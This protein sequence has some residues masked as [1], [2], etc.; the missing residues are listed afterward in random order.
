MGKVFGKWSYEGVTITEMALNDYITLNSKKIFVPHSAGRFNTKRFKKAQ[1]PIVERLTN[2]IMMHGRN[3]GK[4]LMA[5]RIVRH[6]FEI[7]HLLTGNNPLQVLVDAVSFAG[8]R[9]DSPRVGLEVL[10]DDKPSM[11]L[12]FDE[13]TKPS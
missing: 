11:F 12:L 10:P 8:P 13:L 9:E 3:N 1:C 2:S 5:V 4:K 7:I 6:A